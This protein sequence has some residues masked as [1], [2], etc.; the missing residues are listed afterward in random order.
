MVEQYPDTI[1]ITVAGTGTQDANGV[2]TA[3]SATTY[4]LKCRLETNSAGRKILGDDGVLRDYY[5]IAYLPK[6]TTKIPT[7]SVYS[8]VKA[9]GSVYSG[10]VK[11]GSNG[12]LNSRLW[13]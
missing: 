2:W 1:V 11:N 7:E 8:L 3:A 4:T 10:N 6:M 9:D 13:L 12:Q 5:F